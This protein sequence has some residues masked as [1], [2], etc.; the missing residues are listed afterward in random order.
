MS[1]TQQDFSAQPTT[2]ASDVPSV[3]LVRYGAMPQVGRFT[4]AKSE[5]GS[6]N[7]KLQQGDSVVVSTE[8]GIELGRLLSVLSAGTGAEHAMTG[9]VLRIASADDIA[10]VATLKDDCEQQFEA[11][12]DRIKEWNV[13]LQL[14]DVERTLEDDQIILYVL[15]DQNAETTR[16]ALLTA[17]AGHG[18]VHVQPVAADGILPIGKPSGGGCGS[19]GGG[20]GSGGGG[21]GSK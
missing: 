6:N 3:C 2:S 10:K 1:T 11:W 21:C 17:A 14:V 8:R 9:E 7:A 18:I 19:G 20:C 15:N 4:A 13:Q 12:Q 16:L 5:D